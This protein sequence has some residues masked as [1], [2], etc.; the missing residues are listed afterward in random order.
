MKHSRNAIGQTARRFLFSKVLLLVLAFTQ[1]V[2]LAQP[3]IDNEPFES[4]SKRFGQAVPLHGLQY[5]DVTGQV[6]YHLPSIG[7]GMLSVSPT[8]KSSR[9]SNTCTSP[10]GCI[11]R[12]IPS[13]IGHLG[14][15]GYGRLVI[16]NPMDSAPLTSPDRRLPNGRVDFIDGSGVNTHFKRDYMFQDIEMADDFRNNHFIDRTLRRVTRETDKAFGQ[17]NYYMLNPDGTR[18]VFKPDLRALGGAAPSAQQLSDPSFRL[19][20]YPVE[21]QAANGRKVTLHY[22]GNLTSG[23]ANQPVRLNYM[24]DDW[25]R[26]LF[27]NYFSSGAYANHLASIAIGLASGT[28][29]QAKTLM[30][31]G[32]EQFSTTYGT[33]T[34]LTNFTTPEGYRTWLR[35]GQFDRDYFRGINL[36]TGLELPNSLSVSLTYDA[37]DLDVSQN[38]SE[39]YRR[40]S[41]IEQRRSGAT[42]ALIT[43]TFQYQK[44]H[45]PSQSSELAEWLTQGT[46]HAWLRVTQTTSESAHNTSV[47]QSTYYYQNGRGTFENP[48]EGITPFAGLKRA[49]QTT[50]TDQNGTSTHAFEAW[51]HQEIA[52][53]R[54]RTTPPT[55]LLNT[56]DSNAV[57]EADTQRNIAT[58]ISS[59]YSMQDGYWWVNAYGYD[60][61][62]YYGTLPDNVDYTKGFLTPS[63]SDRYRRDQPAS[64]QRKTFLL[65]GYMPMV[66]SDQ[67]CFDWVYRIDRLRDS[68]TFQKINN[69]FRQTSRA[70]LF[71]HYEPHT[72]QPGVTPAKYCRDN[73]RYRFDYS[74]AN[75]RELTRSDYYYSGAYDGMKAYE[76]Q[77][78]AGRITYMAYQYGRPS[79]IRPP[80]GPD[81]VM[82]YNVDGTMAS[83]T[84]N[85]ITLLYS[86]DADGRLVEE[87]ESHGLTLATTHSYATPAELLSHIDYTESRRGTSLDRENYDHLGRLVTMTHRVENNLEDVHT[88]NSFDVMGNEIQTISNNRNANGNFLPGMTSNRVFDVHGRIVREDRQ[89]GDSNTP[90]KQ[91]RYNYMQHSNGNASTF[92][93]VTQGSDTVGSVTQTDVFGRMIRKAHTQGNTTNHGP[94]TQFS[95]GFEGYYLKTVISPDGHSRNREVVRDWLGRKVRE[96]HPEANGSSYYY[97]NDR[98]LIDREYP[99]GSQTA[100]AYV[101]DTQDRLIE[102][103]AIDPSNR[104]AAVQIELLSQKSY[105]DLSRITQVSTKDG[106]A[107]DITAWD[108]ANR[109]ISFDRTLP[110]VNLG[111]ANLAPNGTSVSALDQLNL[112]WDSSDVSYIVEFQK[113]GHDSLIFDT[114][115]AQLSLTRDLIA[116]A[117]Q[118]Q[119]DNAAAM[120]QAYLVGDAPNFLDANS[121]YQWRVRALSDDFIASYN[122]DWAVI[123]G[124]SAMVSHPDTVDFGQLNKVGSGGIQFVFIENLTQTD[125]TIDVTQLSAPFTIPRL[126]TTIPVGARVSF[127]VVFQPTEVGDFQTTIDATISANGQTQELQ[128]PV[129]ATAIEADQPQLAVSFDNGFDGNFGTV[130]AGTTVNAT[131]TLTNVGTGFTSGSI[132]L[133]GPSGQTNAFG[134]SQRS[135]NINE[136]GTISLTISFTPTSNI[137][138]YQV[139]LQFDAQSG[140]GEDVELPLSGQMAYNP[141]E[142]TLVLGDGAAHVHFSGT[143]INQEDIETYLL[144]NSEPGTTVRGITAVVEGRDADQFFVPAGAFGDIPHGTNILAEVGFRPTRSHANTDYHRAQLRISHPGDEDLVVELSGKAIQPASLIVANAYEP[145]VPVSSL[146]FQNALIGSELE[147]VSYRFGTLGNELTFVRFQI[148]GPDAAYFYPK[149]PPP[150]GD[151]FYDELQTPIVFRPTETRTYN[152]TIRLTAISSGDTYDFALSGRGI[153]AADMEL[154]TTFMQN[155][156]FRTAA[157]GEQVALEL[158]L[159]ADNQQPVVLDWEAFGDFADSAVIRDARGMQTSTYQIGSSGS[160][161]EDHLFITVPQQGAYQGGI[162]FSYQGNTILCIELNGTGQ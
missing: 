136:G 62:R 98:G 96:S 33:I 6:N 67:N 42:P 115:Q 133:V 4:D 152:A 43:T 134:L 2:L 103:W 143:Q 10:T 15:L 110:L 88:V 137:S 159:G 65:D 148:L 105:D 59:Y 27:F 1:V 30:S 161:V 122:S 87:R 46:N 21:I 76:Y 19:T 51:N 112:S 154:W 35:Y 117:V 34:R 106:V 155:F 7:D 23:D 71:Y 36:I 53:W 20:F 108:A 93:W 146:D 61:N 45:T 68:G 70:W 123:E 86:Y 139:T 82:T 69:Q 147:S 156:T 24:L 149:Q 162:C 47:S 29:A 135:F 57:L 83:K 91:T 17:G 84:A 95:H 129:I 85:G 94:G 144:S 141:E 150:N 11:E 126:P 52:L 119:Y 56:T 18:M 142:G 60:Y 64:V 114:D 8:I 31:F 32:Y 49:R 9:S 13:E 109:P 100:F 50:Y 77:G 128:I 121:S 138:N 125:L 81:I 90:S 99:A 92:K 107:L 102:T 89:S 160:R 54:T 38:D 72:Y 140:A 44:N 26:R 158:H 78:S 58:R 14:Y 101:Y 120:Q 28:S 132:N 111:P 79:R 5:N 80:A 37:V 104:N 75:N 48:S 127:W 39:L 63:T 131:A 153:S 124:E 118:S 113:E 145:D 40:V 73:I 25:G 97:Y 151:R 55:F 116:A 3:P 41:R 74:D 12:E 22:H 66:A 16:M 157:V 130:P